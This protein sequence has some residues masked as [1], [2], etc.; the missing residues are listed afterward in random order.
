MNSPLS[1][2]IRRFGARRT[3]ACTKATVGVIAL[4]LLAIHPDLQPNRISA[5]IGMAIVLATAIGQIMTRN[6]PGRLIEGPIAASA[7]V[8]IN[9]FGKEQVTAVTLLWIAAVVCGVLARGRD[10]P[11]GSAVFGVALLLPIALTGE[12]R[13]EYFALCVAA[14]A[15]AISG[16]LILGELGGALELARYEADH[17]ILTGTLSRSAFKAALDEIITSPER[18]EPIALMTIDLDEFNQINKVH[19]HAAGDAVLVEIAQRV[20]DCGGNGTIV[21]RLGGDE[22]AAVLREQEAAGCATRLLRELAEGGSGRANAMGSVGIA[23]APKDGDD[24]DSLLRA[25]DVALR[26]AKRSPHPRIS[27]YEGESLGGDGKRGAEAALARLIAGDGIAM[28]AQPIFEL[29]TG[30][31]HSY[32]ALARFHGRA[33]DSPL[34]WFS[35]ADE[36]AKRRDLERACLTE[37]LK[38]LDDLPAGSLLSINLSGPVLG[39]RETAAIFESAPDLSRVIVELTEETLI[40]DPALHA[41]IAV[42]RGRGVSFA[43]DD[44]GAGY[45][46]L[47]QI[48]AV[49]PDYL[50]LDRTMVAG[51]QHDRDRRALVNAIVD[52][53]ERVGAQLVAEGVETT[54]EL[55]AIEALGIHLAQGFLLARP[56]A[57]WPQIENRS[58]LPDA[59]SNGSSKHRQSRRSGR[60]R[61]TA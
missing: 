43:I 51:I 59:A 48:T 14:A 37:A 11:G 47:R 26:V 2:E 50:K 10:N 34:H 44:M 36:F 13:T 32:E 42:L 15:M 31:I 35:L 61:Q 53:V 30:A 9:G 6:E 24:A 29:R 55:E 40:D 23:V 28:V 27:A 52:Y 5:A 46:G 12:M 60:S 22:F 3:L 41:A 4:A 21:G 8:L 57:P 38:L 7:G 18:S 58:A 56:G 16:R 25:A 49:H 1:L 19:G 45:A 33:T 20:R 54:E 17:D 39:D